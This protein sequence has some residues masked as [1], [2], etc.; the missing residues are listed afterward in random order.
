MATAREID[1]RLLRALRAATPAA[2]LPAAGL[3][4]GLGL[5]EPALAARLDG[6]RA[7]GYRFDTVAGR[8]RLLAAPAHL[9]ADDLCAALPEQV[10]GVGRQIV[11][12]AET[13][14]TNDLAA[15][16][17][18]DGVAGGLVIFAEVQRAGRGRLGRRWTAPPHQ[19]LLFSVL[20]R[21]APVPP[22]RW[23]ELTFCA[24][25][26]VA[27]TAEA[28]TG[29]PTRIKWP[30]DVLVEGRK[31]AG[32]LLERHE[33]RP[34]GSL[35]MFT[36]SGRVLER[37]EAAATVLTRLEDIVTRWPDGFADIAAACARRGCT[38]PPE[39]IFPA[40]A[41]T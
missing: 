3:A 10:A 23:P 16:A 19:A 34:A 12:F 5:D 2:G 17:G 18:H 14:S 38:Q 15:R 26:A 21:P 40:A 28:L 4:T 39:E 37:R 32:I 22:G 24:A 36:P 7:A 11:V 13:D 41:P 29:Q 25:L 6:L 35:A 20:L 33:G 9:I 1:S 30:N 8:C 27:E 31:I